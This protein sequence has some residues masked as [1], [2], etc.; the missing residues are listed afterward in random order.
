MQNN[1]RLTQLSVTD[2]EK[3]VHFYTHYLGF[4]ECMQ[5][6]DSGYILLEKEDRQLLISNSL[7][8]GVITKPPRMPLGKG[9]LLEFKFK[10]IFSIYKKLVFTNTEMLP[11]LDG[12]G[13]EGFIAMYLRDPEDYQWMLIRSDNKADIKEENLVQNSLN[14]QIMFRDNSSPCLSA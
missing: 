6:A 1:H 8:Q 5:V 14:V 4:K 13:L 9:I 10:D 11:V 12:I 7:S 3:S 2:I